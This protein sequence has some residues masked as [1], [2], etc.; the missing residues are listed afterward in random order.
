MSEPSPAVDVGEF[1]ARVLG[2]GLWDHQLALL[3]SPAR[4]RAVVAGRQSGKSTSLAIAALFE[5]RNTILGY[6]K[7]LG[8]ADLRELARVPEL[9]QGHLLGNQ[10]S[11]ASLDLLAL[12]GSKLPDD[13]I[14]V[15]RHDYFLSFF[16]RPRWASKRSSALRISER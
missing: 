15:R 11:G 3:R 14:H 8:H 10:L 4:Y 6:A 7:S 5:A 1:A 12:G 9:A 13:V 16:S 2:R